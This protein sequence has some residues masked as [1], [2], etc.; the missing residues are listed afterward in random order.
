MSIE[1]SDVYRSL[2]G[3]HKGFRD[4]LRAL[5]GACKLRRCF[6]RAVGCLQTTQGW[7]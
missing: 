7:L 4:V 1:F 3:L 6:Y 2:G 5:R